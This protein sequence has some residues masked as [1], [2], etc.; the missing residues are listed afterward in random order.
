M[1]QIIPDALGQERKFKSK[2]RQRTLA[3]DIKAPWLGL[4]KIQMYNDEIY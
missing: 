1:E 4:E 2:T 3:V